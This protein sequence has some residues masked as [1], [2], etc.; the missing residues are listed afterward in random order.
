VYRSAEVGRISAAHG[1]HRD[2][3][4]PAG[5]KPVTRHKTAPA[6]PGHVPPYRRAHGRTQA[7]R[8]GAT[9]MSPGVVDQQSCRTRLPAQIRSARRESTRS[10]DVTGA[11]AKVRR[12]A[13]RRRV[14]RVRGTGS[15]PRSWT[16]E[17]GRGGGVGSLGRRVGPWITGVEYGWDRTDYKTWW[18]FAS[19]WMGQSMVVPL[20]GLRGWDGA[21]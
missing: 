17:C 1:R 5:G 18:V 19:F 4:E 3:E 7:G 20:A 13:V 11:T 2:R 9:A 10:G 16:D 12:E 14:R 15:S 21:P 8:E 6:S